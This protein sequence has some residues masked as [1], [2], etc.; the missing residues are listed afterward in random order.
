M[1]PYAY[2]APAGYAMM[3]NMWASLGYNFTGFTDE[4]FSAADHTAAGPFVK[5][6]M[7]IDQQSVKEMV[8]WFVPKK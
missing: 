6:R 2:V 3:K 8:E 1:L 4:K 7:K 5:M